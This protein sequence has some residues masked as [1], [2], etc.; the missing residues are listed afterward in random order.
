MPFT[1]AHPAAVL[2]LHKLYPGAFLAL[3][4]GSVGPDL[5]FFLPLRVLH[6]L[7]NTHS[8]QATLT[9]GPLLAL[10]LL[11]A[12]VLLEPALLQPLWG[13]HRA[14]LEQELSPLRQ[15]RLLPWARA[16]PALWLGSFTHYLCDGATHGEGSIVQL[17]P[18][19]NTPLTLFSGH[20]APLY[21]LLQYTSSLAGLVIL[22]WWYYRQPPPITP[23]AQGQPMT[24][25][26]AWLAFILLG[27]TVLAARADLRTLPY[28]AG[29]GGLL[30]AGLTHFVSDFVALYVLRGL[31]AI[32]FAHVANRAAAWLPARRG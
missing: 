31:S 6:A 15:G 28:H 9:I 29:P 16:L 8:L 25:Q 20:T 12:L 22:A 19:L 27:A 23:T 10:A 18:V 32:A 14:L 30:Y 7:G 24:E 3:A 4:L 17:L 1:L 26:A 13:K 11:I 21:L 2:P 5:P